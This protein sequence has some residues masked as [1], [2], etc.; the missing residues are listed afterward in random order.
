[1]AGAATL[2]RQRRL[3]R[4]ETSGRNP[5]RR[6]RSPPVP[7]QKRLRRGPIEGRANFIAGSSTTCQQDETDRG[8]QRRSPSGNMH[9]WTTISALSLFPCEPTPRS[10]SNDWLE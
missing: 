10:A 5:L 3:E 4:R 1:M 8:E 9:R 7:A 6:D 2:G